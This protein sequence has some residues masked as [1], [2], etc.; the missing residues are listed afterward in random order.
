MREALISEAIEPVVGTIGPEGMTRAEPSLP[1]R[2]LWRGQEYAVAEVLE[3]WKQTGP[4]KGGSDSRYLR[5]HW[6]RIRTA[7]GTEM[8]LYF[9]RQPGP[10]RQATK[11]WWLYAAELQSGSVEMDE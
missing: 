8:K 5:K 9:Q 1:A 6:F 3:K 2:F 11:R 10:G 7:D 4:S